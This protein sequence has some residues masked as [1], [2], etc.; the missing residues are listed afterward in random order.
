PR[1]PHHIAHSGAVVHLFVGG[2]YSRMDS[3]WN[4]PPIGVSALTTLQHDIVSQSTS[5]LASKLHV[6]LMPSKFL[7]VAIALRRASRFSVMSFAR[8]ISAAARLIA[9]IATRPP[10]AA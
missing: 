3:N 9:S 2:A 8:S 1:P 10:S 5:P 6:P 7:V 4:L